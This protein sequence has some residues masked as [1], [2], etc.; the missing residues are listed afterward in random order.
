MNFLRNCA[1]SV[2]ASTSSPVFWPLRRRLAT[3]CLRVADRAERAAFAVY[4]HKRITR[5][6]FEKL[7]A[8]RAGGDA[9]VRS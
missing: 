3:A 9:A 2:R 5:D 1:R 4:P 6:L 7:A 8:L